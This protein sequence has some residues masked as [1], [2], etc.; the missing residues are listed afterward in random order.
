MSLESEHTSDLIF[1]LSLCHSLS[2]TPD[3]TTA[4]ANEVERVR[5]A[6]ANEVE[7]IRSETEG[8]A[9]AA[10]VAAHAA[11]IAARL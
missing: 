4:I 7:R 9:T 11:A 6:V 2:Q 5:L 3:E 8:L 1:S 10:A